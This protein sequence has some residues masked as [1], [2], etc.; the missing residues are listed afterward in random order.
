MDDF[1]KS[2]SPDATTTNPDSHDEKAIVLA[3]LIHEL[4]FWEPSTPNSLALDSDGN[5]SSGLMRKSR[6]VN[7]AVG[8]AAAGHNMR[9]NHQRLSHSTSY[10]GSTT[11]SKSGEGI[12]GSINNTTNNMG[13]PQRQNMASYD[14]PETVGSSDKGTTKRNDDN[15]YPL[16]LYDNINNKN[17]CQ[18][19]KLLVATQQQPGSP[20][21][22]ELQEICYWNKAIDPSSGRT[23]YYD[24]RTRH[25][26]WEKV[27][28]IKVPATVVA[29]RRKMYGT[30]AFFCF[31]LAKRSSSN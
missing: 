4:S 8:E 24:V 12:N 7:D 6:S 17:G 18:D 21:L 26:Q 15:Q 1:N 5:S 25:T 11:N 9:D 31:Y 14:Y 28:V 2:F 29:I 19:E 20:T 22:A 16:S 3:S 13:Y 23:Y 27:R 10:N 30:E